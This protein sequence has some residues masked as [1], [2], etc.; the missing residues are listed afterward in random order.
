MAS[1]AMI[2]AFAVKTCII[3]ERVLD[4]FVGFCEADW[5]LDIHCFFRNV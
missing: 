2:T 3:V 4:V 5:I 1:T